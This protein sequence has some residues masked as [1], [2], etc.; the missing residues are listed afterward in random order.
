MSNWFT[1]MDEKLLSLAS[2]LKAF[3]YPFTTC[4]FAIL[5]YSKMRSVLINHNHQNWATFSF[6]MSAFYILFTLG[7]G[8]FWLIKGDGPKLS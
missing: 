1:W 6:F 2:F 8:I 5:N 4:F 3:I 7:F